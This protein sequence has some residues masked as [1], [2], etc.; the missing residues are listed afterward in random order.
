MIGASF[1]HAPPGSCC[2]GVKGPGNAQACAD[3]VATFPDGASFPGGEPCA[4]LCHRVVSLPSVRRLIEG[5]L[6]PFDRLA[7]DA[8]VS[9]LGRELDLDGPVPPDVRIETRD[10]PGLIRALD[11]PAH[12]RHLVHAAPEE[13]RSLFSVPIL[14][15]P[16]MPENA[17]DFIAPG[18]D[19]RLVRLR[20]T[21]EAQP[22]APPAPAPDEEE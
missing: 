1:R 8:R 6:G 16:T 21:F 5:A 20:L 18:E 9:F 7:P 13:P 15:D 2:C 10:L 4:C 12:G 3:E 11:R 14:T 22:A 19:G 17:I